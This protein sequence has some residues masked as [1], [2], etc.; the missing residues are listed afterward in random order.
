MRFSPVVQVCEFF[1]SEITNKWLQRK[2]ICYE[3][4]QTDATSEC[5]RLNTICLTQHFSSMW[6]PHRLVCFSNDLWTLPILPEGVYVFVCLR[7]CVCMFG[8]VNVMLSMWLLW[9]TADLLSPL[10]G[11]HYAAL[12]QWAWPTALLCL[13]TTFYIKKLTWEVTQETLVQ[14]MQLHPPGCLCITMNW[15]KERKKILWSCFC[16][17]HCSGHFHICS[18]PG[19]RSH[20]FQVFLHYCDLTRY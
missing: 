14:C 7:M 5:Y 12:H 13:Q 20:W 18:I 10:C 16:Y 11:S 9:V 3:S 4:E 2:H 15:K 17:R 8:S 1:P 19:V 6:C